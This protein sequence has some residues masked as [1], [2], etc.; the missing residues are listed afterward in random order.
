MRPMGW[1]IS[2]QAIGASHRR[3]YATVADT[4]ERAKVQVGDYCA[5]TIND[6]VRFERV[7][8]D[9]EV[10]RLGLQPSEVK[11]YAT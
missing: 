10:K 4:H 8:T 1:L 2:V 11:L 5:A 7:L 9:G 6:T 3:L